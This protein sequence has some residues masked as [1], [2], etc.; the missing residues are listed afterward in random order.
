MKLRQQNKILIIDE[1]NYT[2]LVLECA[3][4]TAKYKVTTAQNSEEAMKF[5]SAELPDIILLSLRT[6]D[7]N[8]VSTMKA[9]KDYFRLR[10]DVAHGAEPPIIVLSAFRD[11]VQTREIQSMGVLKLLPK[12]INMQE[13]MD[14]VKSSITSKETFALQTRKTILIFD[15][16][17][18]SQQ[19][20]ESALVCDLIYDIE[21]ADS[22]AELLARIK[23]RKFDLCTID[24][25]SIENNIIETLEKIMEL[26]E[27]KNI[28][29]IATSAD[30]ISQ[31]DIKQLGIQAHFMKPLN[32]NDFRI[33][34]DMLLE[35]QVEETIDES[36]NKLDADQSVGE[37]PIE[38]KL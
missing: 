6:T 3:F 2:R 33:E 35:T 7:S 19:F 14:S 9:L 13:L 18:R 37:E 36:D 38:D 12:P 29:T 24:L 16:E 11:T 20:L 30:Q 28:V 10:L 31:N 15:A 4:T 5:I 17:S 1:I 22:D 27:G 21:T 32:I 26:T 25:T 34:I 8:G 23:R